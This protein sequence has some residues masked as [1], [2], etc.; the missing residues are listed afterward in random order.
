L[1]ILITAHL[2]AAR[3]GEITSSI[4]SELRI[5]MWFVSAALAI[6]LAF[7]YFFLSSDAIIS[8]S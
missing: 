5:S 6:I 7:G 4:P 2:A 8:E 1:I 3:S